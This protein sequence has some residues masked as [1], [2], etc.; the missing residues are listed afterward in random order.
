MISKHFPMLTESNCTCR[1]WDLIIWETVEL[2][3]CIFEYTNMLKSSK[4]HSTNQYKKA[5]HANRKM[6]NTHRTGTSQM[7]K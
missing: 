2:L 4:I 7:K 5:M 1:G 6:G 3:C